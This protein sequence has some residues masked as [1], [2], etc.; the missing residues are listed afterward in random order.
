MPTT[1]YSGDLGN[2]L[3]RESFSR[4]GVYIL[5][6]WRE[7]RVVI[8]TINEHTNIARQG[9]HR[10]R[11]HAFALPLT[12]MAHRVRLGLPSFVWMCSPHHQ[13]ANKN[14]E[15]SR[16]NRKHTRRPRILENI[17][18]LYIRTLGT[19]GLSYSRKWVK[20]L[21]IPLHFM[22]YWKKPEHKR[23]NR[24]THIIKIGLVPTKAI[25]VQKQVTNP[26]KNVQVLK[27]FSNCVVWQIQK[28]KLGHVVHI[29]N[30]DNLQRVTKPSRNETQT[31][32]FDNDKYSTL[33]RL[34][35]KLIVLILLKSHRSR[36]SRSNGAKVPGTIWCNALCLQTD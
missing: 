22:M 24:K 30:G 12:T 20:V 6:H 34:G 36:F 27:P 26:R 8:W 7:V 35:K 19:K 29:G 2:R 32:L 10:R 21:A 25:P 13:N 4:G 3:S 17:H 11:Q 5:G 14:E 16:P 23:L 31:W 1:R 18:S 9:A 15:I 33:V 28:L